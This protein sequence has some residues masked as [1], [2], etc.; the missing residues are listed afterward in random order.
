M[1]SLKFTHIYIYIDK[2][3][4][5]HLPL[6]KGVVSNPSFFINQPMGKASHGHRMPRPLTGAQRQCSAAAPCG[7]P[8]T[9]PAPVGGTVQAGAPNRFM[10]NSWEI[11]GKLVG[12]SMD[13]K[14]HI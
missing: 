12:I 11:H 3:V 5:H 7:S 6:V 10:G 1:K 8:R 4:Y 9:C 2:P 13:F 14:H